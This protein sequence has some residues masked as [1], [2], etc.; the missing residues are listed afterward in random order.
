MKS[1]IFMSR[2]I[3]KACHGDRQGVW[4]MHDEGEGN[5][6]DGCLWRMDVPKNIDYGK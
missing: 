3:V 5:K 4:R 2:P 6:D 1:V